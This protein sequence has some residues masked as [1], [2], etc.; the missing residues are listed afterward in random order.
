M[1]KT[2]SGSGVR[3]GAGRQRVRHL[4]MYRNETAAGDAWGRWLPVGEAQNLLRRESLATDNAAVD[5]CPSVVEMIQPAGG[6][7]KDGMYVELYRDGQNNQRFY[8]VSCRPDVENKP[9]RFIERRLHNQSHCVQTY[10]YSYAL[11][12]SAGING[13][14]TFSGPAPGGTGS[15]TMD[16][17]EV[18]SGCSCKLQP[19]A[20][21]RHGRP[22]HKART[23]DVTVTP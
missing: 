20:R 16:Y 15:W 21:H 11:V 3:G 19:R 23:A 12:R 6:K 18:R 5:C 10:S 8:E 2:A 9:C 22:K 13:A 14:S 1:V 17:I 7:N 4:E